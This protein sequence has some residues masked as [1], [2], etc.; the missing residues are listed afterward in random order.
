M[1]VRTIESGWNDMDQLRLPPQQVEAEAAILGGL[2]LDSTAYDRVGDLL[3]A[4]DFYRHEYR[5]I[6]ST[7]AALVN[8]GKPA[9]VVTVAV[10]LQRQGEGT[11][12]DMA[13]LNELAQF[14]PSTANLRRYAELV[15]DSSLRRKLIAVSDVV[16]SSAFD[17]KGKSAAML[18]DEAAQMLVGMSPEAKV[19]EWEAIDASLLVEMDRIQAR[20]EGTVTAADDEVI[21]THISALDEL[22]DGGL[23]AG[24]LIII[25]ARPGMGKSALG[26]TIGL[27]VAIREHISVGKFSMEMQNREGAQRALASVG[28]VP[29]HALRRPERMTDF[30]WGRLVEGVEGLRGVPFYSNEQAGLNISQIRSK[31]RALA[32]SKGLGLLVVDYL[33]LMSG[34]DPKAPRTYQLEEASRGLKALAKELRIPVIALAQVNRSVEK[35]LNPMPRM[36]DLKDCGAIEQDADVILFLHRPG[37]ANPGEDE[38]KDYAKGHVAKHRG[39]RTG[40][41]DLLYVGE[42]TRF[43]DWPS[44]RPL[45][46]SRVQPKAGGLR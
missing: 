38:W 9:D 31:A 32:K 17:P 1:I 8:A 35:E 2:L 45:P 46:I 26:D 28:H 5:L 22:L 40:Y 37:V 19:D 11:G 20:A 43:G 34:T 33:Q 3:A 25:G 39:G 18:M 6:F 13:M 16:A 10:E 4:N 30:D 29:L 23:R 36:S 24:Q 7:I 12:I 14:V 15:R 27:N 44:T 42:N 41:V 21:P